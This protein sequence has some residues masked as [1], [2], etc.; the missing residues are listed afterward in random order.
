MFKGDP[1]RQANNDAVGGHW[2][3]TDGTHPREARGSIQSKRR[4]TGDA[5]SQPKRRGQKTK[6]KEG[7]ALLIPQSLVD[8]TH[9]L[10]R[11]G[12]PTPERGTAGCLAG[13][14]DSSAA[15]ALRH[16]PRRA[17][18]DIS[19]RRPA[20]GQAGRTVDP[21][22]AGGPPCAWAVSTLSPEAAPQEPGGLPASP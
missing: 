4:T 5:L 3:P 17:Q 22:V 6:H 18:N 2:T 8:P 10:L 16:P 15:P 9:H 19:S 1:D 7:D 21:S 20:A 11:P 13:S 14:P 12:P